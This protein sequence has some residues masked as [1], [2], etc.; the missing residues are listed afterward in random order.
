MNKT[1][2]LSTLCIAAELSRGMRRV[3]TGVRWGGRS[4]D[5]ES[6]TCLTRALCMSDIAIWMVETVPG[7]RRLCN[8]SNADQEWLM[9]GRWKGMSV[10]P[11]RA[12]RTNEAV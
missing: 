3:D 2:S 9:E 10:G 4:R 6:R 12:A 7:R 11:R 5:S 8:E 1:E